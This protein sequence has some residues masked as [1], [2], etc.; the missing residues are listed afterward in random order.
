MSAG[1]KKKNSREYPDESE[2][3]RTRNGDHYLIHQRRIERIVK[4]VKVLELQK[5]VFSDMLIDLVLR[6]L[7]EL[8]SLFCY[9]LL[10]DDNSFHT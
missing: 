4:T 5:T 2:I 7:S 6:L 8:L 3:S 1:Q 9:L 10:I